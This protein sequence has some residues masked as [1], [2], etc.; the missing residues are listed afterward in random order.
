MT[1]VEVGHPAPDPF[2][3][4]P[5][6]ARTALSSTWLERPAVLAFLRHFG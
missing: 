3:L 5:D 1:N 2:V 6:G 4:D